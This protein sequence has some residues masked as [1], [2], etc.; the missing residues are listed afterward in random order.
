MFHFEEWPEGARKPQTVA[1]S[2]RPPLCHG[3][4]EMAV[5]VWIGD[6]LPCPGQSCQCGAVQYREEERGER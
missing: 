6:P 5:H 3:E 4:G 1:A 2:F